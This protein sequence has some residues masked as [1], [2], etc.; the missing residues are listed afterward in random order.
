MYLR[1]EKGEVKK[2]SSTVKENEGRYLYAPRG[3]AHQD[4]KRQY[5]CYDLCCEKQ[6]RAEY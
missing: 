6:T 5:S 1:R 3:A 2:E 4:E